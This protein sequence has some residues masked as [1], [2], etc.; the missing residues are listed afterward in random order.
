V[1]KVYHYPKCSTCKNALK[2]LKAKGL[3]Y[4]EEDIKSSPPSDAELKAM[5]KVYEGELRKLFNTSGMDYR[6]LGLKD[7]L[8]TMSEK[9]AFALLRSNGMLVKRPFVL[10]EGLGV[11]GFKEK[12][13]TEKFP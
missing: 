5:L 4:V 6:A 7:Q 13:W 11:V 3:E 8:P 9:D 1:L 2:W 12:E 10:G